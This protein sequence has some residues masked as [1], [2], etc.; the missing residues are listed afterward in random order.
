MSRT[1]NRSVIEIRTHHEGELPM[2]EAFA[3][4]YAQVIED[5]LRKMN[6]STHLSE[7]EMQDNL[8][9]SERRRYS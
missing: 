8:K 7:D 4:V 3:N 5:G 9:S 2:I 6:N 1:I